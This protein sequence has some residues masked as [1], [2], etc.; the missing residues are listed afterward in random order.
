M[1][2]TEGR[3]PFRGGVE[4]G[5]GAVDLD[6][7]HRTR[8]GRKAEVERG[9]DGGDDRAVHHL[10]GCRY[11]PGRDDRGDRRGRLGNRREDREHRRDRLGQWHQAKRRSRHDA[12]GAL[13]TADHAGQVVAERVVVETV[14]EDHDLAVGEHQLDGERAEV[15]LGDAHL[16]AHDRGA[17]ARRRAGGS[18]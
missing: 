10:E 18:W 2:A 8:V 9:L 7:E 11:D 12:H 5:G 3:N 13:G 14:P 15:G 6:D 4:T 16:L 1:R 17:P